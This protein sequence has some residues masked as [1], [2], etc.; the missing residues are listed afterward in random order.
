MIHHR[1]SYYDFYE[2]MRHQSIELAE[3]RDAFIQELKSLQS[4]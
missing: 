4:I 1:A 2:P 3:Q